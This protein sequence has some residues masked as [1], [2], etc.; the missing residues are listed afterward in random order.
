MLDNSILGYLFVKG[1]IFPVSFDDD[2]YIGYLISDVARMMRTVFDRRVRRLGLTRAQWLVLT[3]LHRRPGA[4][5]SELAEMLEVEKA[6]AGRMIDRLERNGWVERRPDAG[7]RR[8]NR[9]YLTA[10]AERMQVS[11][12]AISEQTVDDAL[13]SLSERDRVQ[14]TEFM[15]QVKTRLQAMTESDPV[16]VEVAAE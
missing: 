13:A 2:R 4:S 7:D 1:R 3:R 5:Q 12:R 14:L 10:E 8:I 11:L 16:G 9:L 15:S 6:T